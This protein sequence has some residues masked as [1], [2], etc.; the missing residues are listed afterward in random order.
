MISQTKLAGDYNEKTVLYAFRICAYHLIK[1]AIKSRN[2]DESIALDYIRQLN[3]ETVT[4]E[5]IVQLFVEQV[6]PRLPN[7]IIPSTGRLI[8]SESSGNPLIGNL[9]SVYTDSSRCEKCNF[10]SEY[11]AFI[12]RI[13]SFVQRTEEAL[14][15]KLIQQ[16]ALNKIRLFYLIECYKNGTEEF[17]DTE[18]TTICGTRKGECSNTLRIISLKQ[19]TYDDKDIG[20]FSKD[21]LKDILKFELPNL[22]EKR[23]APQIEL[24]NELDE[25]YQ[26]SVL[27]QVQHVSDSNDE[28]HK[29]QEPPNVIPSEQVTDDELD[30]QQAKT[31]KK[32]IIVATVFEIIFAA[33]TLLSAFVVA[34]SQLNFINISLLN[35]ISNKL[36]LIVSSV[37]CAVSAVAAAVFG[38]Y[39][40]NVA[41][42]KQ[43]NSTAIQKQIDTNAL[44]QQGQDQYHDLSE[45][46][47]SV[48]QEIA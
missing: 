9:E 26:K 31:N 12:N 34:N 22:C 35:I 46:D 8:D 6:V 42:S 44:K 11:V 4:L 14:M 48:N 1:E 10:I 36:L 21:E 29:E 40:Y 23:V 32:K 33:I 13:I 30:S 2:Q 38:I 43:I 24:F 3:G 19:F 16:L 25:I 27:K 28:A 20:D 5:Q 18:E 15:P 39:I 45:K 17:P 41:K 37:C 47:Q 7:C